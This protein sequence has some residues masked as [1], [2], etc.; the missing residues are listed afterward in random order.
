LSLP[1]ASFL[2][3]ARKKIFVKVPEP[4]W[5]G[6]VKISGQASLDTRFFVFQQS[7]NRFGMP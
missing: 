2:F 3:L 7:F 5:N 4:N 6:L 1:Q